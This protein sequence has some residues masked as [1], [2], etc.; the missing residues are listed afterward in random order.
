MSLNTREQSCE[1]LIVVYGACNLELPCRCTGYSLRRPK[2]GSDDAT[3][4]RD[5]DRIMNS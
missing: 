3:L 5:G 1:F 2:S 4:A